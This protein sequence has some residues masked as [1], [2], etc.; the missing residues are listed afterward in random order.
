MGVENLLGVRF[1]P[2]PVISVTLVM[3][4]MLCSGQLQ[5]LLQRLES[6]CR[7]SA[8]TTVAR[9][10]I[11]KIIDAAG[12]V[13]DVATPY[14]QL[15]QPAYFNGMLLIIIIAR[16][17][18]VQSAVL[19]LHVCPTSVRPSVTLVDQDHIC[20]KSWKLLARTINPTSSLFVARRPSTYSQRNMGKFWGD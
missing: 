16:C 10:R 5:V 20:W 4:K 11:R 2:P 17:T 3:M 7:Q 6:H 15:R 12:Y 13:S 18:L 9:Q 8:T 14:I 1:P 19:K